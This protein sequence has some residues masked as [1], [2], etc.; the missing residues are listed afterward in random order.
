MDD[1]R[2]QIIVLNIA[3]MTVSLLAVT[4]RLLTRIFLIKRIWTD[5]VLITIALFLG[6]AQASCFIVLSAS[7][8]ASS[9]VS[10]TLCVPWEK[11]WTP[12]RP[13][14]CIDI[15]AYYTAN[16]ALNMVLDIVI[17]ILPIPLLWA[18]KLPQRQRLCLVVVFALGLIVVIASIL[19]LH[20]L[21]IMFNTPAY[22]SDNTWSTVDSINW[23]T[24]EVH[25]AIL[26]SCTAA[27][28]TL[29]QRFLPGIIGSLSATKQNLSRNRYTFTTHDGGYLRQARSRDEP[30][31]K[32]GIRESVHRADENGS[33][34]HIMEDI[35]MPWSSKT[36]DV[37]AASETSLN[38]GVEDAGIGTASRNLLRW[39]TIV[40]GH[41][42]D[43]KVRGRTLERVA[44]EL[45]GIRTTNVCGQ[46]IPSQCDPYS[47]YVQL[48]RSSSLAGI[49]LLSK[50]RERDI[51]GNTVPENM[52]A[53]EKRLEELSEATIREAE[54]WDW[55]SPP[56]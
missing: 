24:V 41:V 26:V 39:V 23:S 15:K 8:I 31:P 10:M 47:L 16:S 6:L 7:G 20:T 17:F 12:N 46:A 36:R 25:L 55:P 29:I 53:A 32:T 19:R 50:V 52:V 18:L 42:T 3:F 35:E 28:K 38:D 33:Q 44:L 34:E 2:G 37:Q 13:G 27:F 48:S 21:L 22:R 43:Y 40:G 30:N 5:D 9:I 45:R 11:L 51:I 4:I 49:M 14:H 54:S 1:R 56:S